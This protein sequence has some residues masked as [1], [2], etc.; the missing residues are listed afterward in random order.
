MYYYVYYIL[1]SIALIL[2]WLLVKRR[3][4]QFLPLSVLMAVT[5]TVEVTAHLLI[6]ERIAFDWL[7]HL[8]CPV[9]FAL[10]VLYLRNSIISSRLRRITLY[11]IVVFAF[12]SLA[13]S[14][15]LYG[16]KSIP[17]ANIGTGSVLL[18]SLCTYVLF[19]LNAEDE[20]P[21]FL[22]TNFWICAGLLLFFGVCTFFFGIYKPLFDLNAGDAY[23]LFGLIVSPLN[24]L[25]YLFII[26]GLLCSLHKRTYTSSSSS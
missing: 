24:L 4:K 7:Y 8:Y 15:F 9:E 21:I 1:I 12:V 10:L 23:R 20:R 16:F 26:L 22:L 19:N 11:C 6:V 17:G 5:L 2:S 3:Q 18:V 13:F 14:T 25:L